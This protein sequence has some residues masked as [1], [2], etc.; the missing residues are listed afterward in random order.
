MIFN[1]ELNRMNQREIYKKEAAE[2]ACEFIKDNMVVGLGS[3][4]TTAYALKKISQLIHSNQ[5]QNIF[6]IPSSLDTAEKAHQLGI[7]ITD[8]KNHPEIDITIDGADEVDENLNVIK[9]GGG[10]HL[11]EKIV[12][13]A[14]KRNIVIID[15]SKLSNKLGA[16]WPVPVEVLPFAVDVEIK[17]LKSLGATINIRKNNDSSLF[18][19]N[20]ANLIIDA[21]FDILKDPHNLNNILNSRAG[22][23]EHGLFVGLVTD[24]IVAGGDGIKEM[25][26]KR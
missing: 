26:V 21:K 24:V 1:K 22:I 5:L 9:G 6:G 25:H 20:Q 12:F 7:P 18:Y 16:N 10:A 4:S 13:Q 14:S 3:G 17:F 11:R 19:T 15:E 23:M 8:F 2:K